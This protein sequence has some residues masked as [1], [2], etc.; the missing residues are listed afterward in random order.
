[1]WIFVCMGEIF[2][3]EVFTYM[4]E[5][6]NAIVVYAVYGGY[7]HKYHE[8]RSYKLCQL[9]FLL[10]TLVVLYIYMY[11]LGMHIACTM[12]CLI[13]YIDIGVSM[14]TNPAW[15]DTVTILKHN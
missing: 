9:K 3:V 11:M 1:M 15:H 7:G 13:Q 5:D 12:T 10:L 6:R 2:M 14:H 4:F 8:F